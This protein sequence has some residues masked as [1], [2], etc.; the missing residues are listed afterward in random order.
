MPSRRDQGRAAG[1]AWGAGAPGVPPE[2]GGNGLVGAGASPADRHWA[3]IASAK[4]LAL[5]CRPLPGYGNVE[6]GW[7]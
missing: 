2:P 1:W 7:G 3:L 6:L 4:E 5:T